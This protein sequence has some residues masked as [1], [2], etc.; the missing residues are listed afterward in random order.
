[1]AIV[2][3]KLSEW[4]PAPRDLTETSGIP[5]AGDRSKAWLAKQPIMAKL[6]WYNDM[7]CMS[8]S[9]GY[10]SVVDDVIVDMLIMSRS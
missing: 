10:I 6:Y 7:R 1:M 4:T 8:G 5:D 9:A 3:K 2:G